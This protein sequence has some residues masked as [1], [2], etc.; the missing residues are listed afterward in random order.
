MKLGMNYR[1]S[2]LE[3]SFGFKCYPARLSFSLAW[4]I[5]EIQLIEWNPGT[6]VVGKQVFTTEHFGSFHKSQ[7]P[8]N[9]ICLLLCA[10]Y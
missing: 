10:F 3:Y 6:C 8:G 7:W 5:F 9:T 1:T 2:H 4:H